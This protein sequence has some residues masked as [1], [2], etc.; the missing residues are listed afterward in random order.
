VVILPERQPV[1]PLRCR[2]ELGVT[3]GLPVRTEGGSIPFSVGAWD[4]TGQE[5]VEA[6]MD[7]GGRTRA[8]TPVPQEAKA[9]MAGSF[10]F[11]GIVHA[12]YGHFLVETLARAWAL[13][14]SDLPI[15]WLDAKG[16][17]GFRPFQKQVLD[18]LGIDPARHV[19]MEVPTRFERLLVPEAG[20]V[21]WQSFH[22]Q[23]A[24]AM[25]VVPFAKPV[26]GKCVWLSRSKISEA[27]SR[28]VNEAE[29]E[30]LLIADGWTIMHPEDH[31]I[32]GQLAI[33]R[34]AETLAGFDGSA[35][36][37]LVLAGGAAARLIL[38]PRHGAN[39]ISSTFQ[40]IS[41]GKGLEQRML[42]MEGVVVSGERRSSK[43]GA[44]RSVEASFL[45]LRE[46]VQ[47]PLRPPVA[48]QAEPG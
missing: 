3:L 33:M 34:D 38:V 46:M 42:V 6:R 36:H 13:L 9:S 35:F 48:H 11:G 16:K 30:A 32:R 18:I 15:I 43:I 37:T 44:L 14:P 26:P 2:D 25:G 10:I 4:A 24:R 31:D 41:D 20:A 1:Q 28:M 22:P 47:Q 45:A 21:L 40:A 29:L 23:H 12:H 17:H 5:I 19:F 27:K 8:G 39:H 7:R